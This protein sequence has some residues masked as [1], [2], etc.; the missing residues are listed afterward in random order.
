MPDDEY[1]KLQDLKEQFTGDGYYGFEAQCARVLGSLAA[2]IVCRECI[3]WMGKGRD[4]RSPESS[5]AARLVKDGYFYRSHAEWWEYAALTR[6]QLDRARGLLKD[7]G[8]LLEERELGPDR[9]RCVY[10]ALDLAALA[11]AL[12]VEIEVMEPETSKRAG[13]MLEMST[14]NAQDEHG[15]GPEWGEAMLENCEPMPESGT[16]TQREPQRE[17]SEE[18][19]EKTP[20]KT[21]EGGTKVSQKQSVREEKRLSV[22]D[23]AQRQVQDLVE[24]LGR[25][26]PPEELLAAV[27]EKLKVHPDTAMRSRV[28][29][30]VEDERGEAA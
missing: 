28:E 27:C 5:P 25:T 16:V 17:S 1:A 8:I 29:R 26:M 19:A 3:F 21:T 24:K 12:D 6:G 22:D 15:P 4:P 30:A 20:K 14:D 7:R 11:R 13:T 18:T 10:Y 9:R 2:G 23:R